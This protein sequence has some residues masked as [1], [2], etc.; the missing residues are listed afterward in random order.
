MSGIS[1][2]QAADKHSSCIPIAN[3]GV[4]HERERRSLRIFAEGG[5]DR[6]PFKVFHRQDERV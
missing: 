6:Q 1:L 5:I 4:R 2:A 3:N